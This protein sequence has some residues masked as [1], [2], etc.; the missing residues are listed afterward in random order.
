MPSVTMARPECVPIVSLRIMLTRQRIEIK[1]FLQMSTTLLC[2]LI[3]GFFG[4]HFNAIKGDIIM[5][6]EQHGACNVMFI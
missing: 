5:L 1:T 6:Y 3:A 4:A 2:Y